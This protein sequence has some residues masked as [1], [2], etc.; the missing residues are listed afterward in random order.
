VGDNSHDMDTSD[1]HCVLY[2]DTC[3]ALTH[4]LVPC[5]AHQRSQATPRHVVMASR[6][7]K[8]L[9][10]LLLAAVQQVRVPAITSR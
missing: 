5:L 9:L 3:V 8:L 6:I 7:L 1:C 4:A 10:L 2:H